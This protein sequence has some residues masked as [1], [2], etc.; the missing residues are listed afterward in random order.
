MWKK[1]AA[2]IAAASALGAGSVG[3][4]KNL[5]FFIGE[6]VVKVIDGDTVILE[7]HQSIKLMGVNAPEPEHCYGSQSTLYLRK[8]VLGKRIF[9]REP[10]T[11]QYRRIVALVYLD[12]KLVNEMMIRGGY[13]LFTRSAESATKDMQEANKFARGY[14]LGIFSPDC[15]QLN[16]PDPKCVIKGNLDRDKN[17]WVY[18]RPDCSYYDVTVVEKFLGERWFCTESEAKRA[19]FTKFSYCK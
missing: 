15:Y 19:G 1:L 13:G 11:D 7:N 9:L 2:G 10:V 5:P 4:Y 18:L 3:V 17:A 12:R 6:K 16:P 14:S 8:L